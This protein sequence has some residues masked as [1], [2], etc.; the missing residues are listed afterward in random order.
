MLNQSGLD[1]LTTTFIKKLI[2]LWLDEGGASPKY[3]RFLN[4]WTME[5]CSWE[6]GIGSKE[7]KKDN[8]KMK[9]KKQKVKQIMRE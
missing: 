5:G 2:T 4:I 8:E 7:H 6:G 1:L 3:L 9:R